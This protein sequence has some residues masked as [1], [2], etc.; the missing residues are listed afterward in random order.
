MKDYEGFIQMNESTSE[1]TLLSNLYAFYLQKYTA[2]KSAVDKFKA[3]VN[4]LEAQGELSAK[5]IK[6][7]YKEN[8][9]SVEKAEPKTKKSKETTTDYGCGSTTI[10]SG[11]GSTPAP[12]KSKPSIGCGSNSISVGCGSTPTTRYSS[13]CGGGGG[14]S[15]STGC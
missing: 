11:C 8:D 9:I 13:G 5:S 12:K 6:K 4:F 10:S 14:Y 1:L 3:Q 7:F 2:K 15:R